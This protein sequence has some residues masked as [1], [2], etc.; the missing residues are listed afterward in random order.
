MGQYQIFAK[1][2]LPQFHSWANSKFGGLVRLWRCLDVHNHMRIG[3][4]Q[5]LRALQDLGYSGDA[6][7]LF[8]DLNRDQTGTL[9]FYHFAPEAALAVGEFLHWVRVNHGTLSEIGI[10]NAVDKRNFITRA[11]FVQICKKKGFS[12]DTA[13]QVTF[14]LLDKDGE[15][16]LVKSELALLDSWDF[17]EWL[18]AKPDDEAALTCKLK[19]LD[20]CQ[21]NALLAWRHL[22]KNGSMR[23][24]W[25]DFR[26]AC[27][28]LLSEDVQT[29][30]SAWRALDDDLSGWLSLREFDRATYDQLSRFV[31]WADEGFGSVHGAFPKLQANKDAKI[32]QTEFRHVVKGCGLGDAVTSKIFQGL[33]LDAT[34]GVSMNELRFL[35]SWQV[36]NDLK[37][38]EAWASLTRPTCTA[39][40]APVSP[41]RVGRGSVAVT[42]P[43]SDA[44][45]RLIRQ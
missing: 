15:G 27:R 14:D 45:P 6:R 34:G 37:E 16:S 13:L 11:Q 22:D 25:H 36:S 42:S 7:E 31:K 10:S 4:G 19:L 5:F 18:T 9:L 24:A 44:A 8:R 30:A 20:R 39:P 38:E 41:K 29:L 1:G 28:K 32:T 23:V 21:G 3:Q 40:T 26:Q 2:G 35:N 17:P 43:R 12:N 33:D